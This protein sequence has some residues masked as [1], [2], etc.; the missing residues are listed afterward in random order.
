MNR[1]PKLA[2]QCTEIGQH[3]DHL[4]ATHQTVINT[5]D[6]PNRIRI[7]LEHWNGARPAIAIDLDN[8][9]FDL[10]G[11]SAIRAGGQLGLLAVRLL[12]LAVQLAF[13][14]HTA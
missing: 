4:G 9:G 8:A 6:G 11:W 14:R 7:Q 3:W 1:C 13:A 2:G 10:A 12:R 5:T